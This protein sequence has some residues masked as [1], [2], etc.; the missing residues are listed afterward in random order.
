MTRE[1]DIERLLDT[2]FRDGPTEAPDRIVDAVADQI[3]RQS[4]RP[5]WR[6][7][8]RPFV[9][10]TAKLAAG[11]A[12]VLVVGFVGWQ[13]LPGGSG[14]GGGS[15]PTAVPT[16]VTPTPSP[17][18][19]ATPFPCDAGSGCA[20]KLDAGAHLTAQFTP[21]FSYTVADAGWTNPV[22][23]PELYQ[24]DSSRGY[25]LVVAHPAIAERTAACEETPTEGYGTAPADW[26]Q[27]VSDHPGLETTRVQSVTIGGYRGQSVDLASLT[28]WT[29]PCAADDFMP[30]LVQFIV[31][32][33]PSPLGIYGVATGVPIRL[34]ALDVL[35]ETVLI[36][37]YG[38]DGRFSTSVERAQAVIDTMRFSRSR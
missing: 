8:W 12:A 17:T 7:D 25:I 21:Q 2:W 30:N 29:S 11:L 13:L 27:F 19:S 38:N 10:P 36:T 37:F 9:N 3:G 16:A 1:R 34:I 6:L 24:L 22:D 26:I 20:G 31:S 33:E 15:L 35:G 23:H 5:A 14:S 28:S 32:S 4:Q 18:P